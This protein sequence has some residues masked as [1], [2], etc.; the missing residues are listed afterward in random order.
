[1]DRDRRLQRFRLRLLAAFGVGML[2]GLLLSSGA[3]AETS[4][5]ECY[6]LDVG[7]ASCLPRASASE[8]LDRLGIGSDDDCTTF[9]VPDQIVEGVAQGEC[10]YTIVADDDACSIDYGELDCG[11]Y[12]RPY[13]DHAEGSA[14]VVQAPVVAS[15]SWAADASAP[16][17]ELAGLSAAERAALAEFWAANAQ[18]EHSSVA[19]FHRLCLELIAH[20]A[21]LELL[22]RSQRAAADELAHARLCFALATHYAGGAEPLGPGPMPLGVAAPIAA[23][24]IELA[25]TTAKE[26]CLGETS[27]AWL[28]S[29]LAAA[30]T[31]PGVRAALEQ[32]AAD[33][34]EHA[35]LAWMTLRWAIDVGGAPVREAVAAVFAAARPAHASPAPIGVPAHG[36]LAEA[37]VERIVARGFAELL[38]PMIHASLSVRPPPSRAA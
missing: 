31:D 37:D 8:V 19:G 21:P 20:G 26:G 10:C 33:E 2:P 27:A 4:S 9:T 15:P 16:V 7:E 30:A 14:G 24:L 12:G 5:T 6:V 29:E 38:T 18:A 34:A 13:V 22:E 11:C 25:V 32:I 1:M 28:A 35:E 3:E 23:D 17:P 36:L